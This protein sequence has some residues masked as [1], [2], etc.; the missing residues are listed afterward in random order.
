MQSTI[1]ASVTSVSLTLTAAL[2]TGCTATQQPTTNLT[3][4]QPLNNSR[5]TIT[6]QPTA[7]QL[8]NLKGTNTLVINSRTDA[9]SS[10]IDFNQQEL[11]NQINVDY[12]R[13]PMGGDNGYTPDQVAAFAAAFEAH[14]GPVLMH[15]AS[16]G[17]S[18]TLYAAYLIEYK[19]FSPDRAMDV[20]RAMGQ[21]PS[22]LE[23]LLGERLSIQR[24]G[25]AL[26]TE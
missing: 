26:P 9:E 17:R 6:G 25:K 11:L 7:E 5:V 10:R 1:K 18:R 24:T 8:N 12:A 2:L 3:Q 20:I 15:C 16:G 19:N 23:M 21:G 4:T 13:V 14:D 22:G